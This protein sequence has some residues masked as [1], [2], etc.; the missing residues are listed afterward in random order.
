MRLVAGEDRLRAAKVPSPV[1]STIHT[2]SLEVVAETA[3]SMLP[4]LSKSAGSFGL[5]SRPIGYA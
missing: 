3:M 1:P 2:P 5:A 4:S